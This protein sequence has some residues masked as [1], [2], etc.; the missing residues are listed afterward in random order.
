MSRQVLTFT[1]AASAGAI[2]LTGA[3]AGD[4][5]IAVIGQSVGQHF[6]AEAS[7]DFEDRITVDNQI[8]Q[9]GSSDLSK[10]D[11]VVVLERTDTAAVAAAGSAQGDAAALTENAYNIVSAADG[12][13]GVVL[14][15]AVVGKEVWVYNTHASNGLKVY[16][17]S[18]DDINDGTTDAAITIE[19]KTLAYFKALDTATWAAIY[20]VNS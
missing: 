16:P 15:A 18:G 5:V 6:V 7:V 13:K 10:R 20:T 17:A 2:T 12:T 11:Y 1:G 19:G 9:G 14:P 8:Q 4:K 3:V